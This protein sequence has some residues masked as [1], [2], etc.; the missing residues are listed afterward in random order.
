MTFEMR[1]DVPSGLSQIMMDPVEYDPELDNL[2][3]ILRDICDV[4]ETAGVC[5]TVRVCSDDDWPVTVTTD[6]VVVLEQI[7]DVLASLAR[8]QE[9]T[10]DFYEQGV[11]RIVTFTPRNEDMLIQCNDMITKPSS[12]TKR[13]T[14]PR[15][16]V[17]REL[18]SLVDD[19]LRASSICSPHLTKHPW[20]VEWTVGLTHVRSSFA[21]TH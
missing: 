20:F 1:L 3:S 17:L 14:T 8:N 5:F 15:D 6:L 9:C 19:F 7:G 2:G 16:P 21:L 10:L 13:L 12:T 4:L 18:L 11:E